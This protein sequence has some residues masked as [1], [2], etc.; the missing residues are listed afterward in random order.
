MISLSAVQR[1]VC[2]ILK[3]FIDAQKENQE[4]DVWAENS[5][6]KKAFIDTLQDQSTKW[7]CFVFW[8]FIVGSKEILTNKLTA[9]KYIRQ[10]LLY[11]VLKQVPGVSAPHD[12]SEQMPLPSLDLLLLCLDSS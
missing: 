11:P 8:L 12:M 7:K 9:E 4:K 3:Q 6:N 2:K 1:K 10:Q 5:Q